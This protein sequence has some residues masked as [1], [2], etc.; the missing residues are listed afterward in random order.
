VE[1]RAMLDA[2]QPRR[3]LEAIH[4]L[5]TRAVQQP[6]L[7]GLEQGAQEWATATEYT[8]KGEFAR[9]LQGLDRAAVMLPAHAAV[10]QQARLAVAQKQ[11]EFEPL[12][13][14]LHEAAQTERWPEALQVSEKLLALAPQHAEIRRLRGRAW[15]A[16]EPP[17]VL[18][19]RPQDKAVAAPAGPAAK[20]RLILWIDG[21][22]GYLLLL[23]NVVT[24]GQAGPDNGADIPLFADVSRL[25]A[26]L[27]RDTEGYI[28]EAL[29]PMT[30][31][32]QGVEKTLLRSGDR[33]T[34]GTSCQLVFRQ[35]VPISASA[36]LELV[37]GH[38]FG[39]A[40]DGVLLMAETLVL[41][42]EG[43][44]HVQISDLKR[45]VIL[46]R[47][48]DEIS[49]RATEDVCM[50][51]QPIHGRAVL[52]PGSSVTGSAF[53]LS[54]ELVDGSKQGRTSNYAVG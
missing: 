26:R 52:E 48:K 34:L 29:R 46:Y 14:Q 45:P 28:V 19:A 3:A 13:R 37:S 27:T 2:G 44:S 32:N 42:A 17:T 8:D 23:D 22:G 40:V 35:D 12:I 51:G 15:K 31:N 11:R 10:L 20:K 33:L 7:D 16:L 38:R 41:G 36:R 25:H 47:N 1:I 43:Q 54:L 49:V 39:Q 50:N 18:L 53:S 21:V 4:H 24:L 6:E 30:V 9:A 5:R